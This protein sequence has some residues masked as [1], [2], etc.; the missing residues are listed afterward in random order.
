MKV[1]EADKQ[2]LLIFEKGEKLVEELT[3][4]AKDNKVPGA[5]IHGIGA[6][7]NAELGYYHLEDKSYIRQT[8]T[9]MD[10][11]LISLHGNITLKEGQPFIHVHASLGRDDFSVFGGHL[12]E[13]EVAVTVEAYVTPFGRIPR[14][15]FDDE[16]GLHLICGI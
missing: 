15:E 4:F 1:I 7:K 12:F 13:A 8:F 14:R 9:D 11:E 10:Y 16:I 2:Y 6:L 3:R 5:R